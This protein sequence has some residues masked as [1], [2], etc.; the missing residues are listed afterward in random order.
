MV[1]HI[2]LAD[3]LLI[4]RITTTKPPKYLR[5]LYDKPFNKMYIYFGTGTYISVLELVINYSLAEYICVSVQEHIF[6]YWNL[7]FCTEI[8]SV[9]EYIL[10]Y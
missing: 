9:L 3:I 10:L 8:E 1:Y 2:I 4:A 6:L 5:V 7:Q